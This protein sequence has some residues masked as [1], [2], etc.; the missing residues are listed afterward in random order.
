MHYGL[1]LFLAMQM[2]AGSAMAYE[3]ESE[4]L[5]H[6]DRLVQR[7]R[8]CAD[9]WLRSYDEKHG[10]F[11]SEVARDGSPTSRKRKRILL[12]SRNVYGL[13]RAFQVTGETRYLE[14]ADET[15][16]FM[17]Q[18]GWDET[19][20]GWFSAVSRSGEL[21]GLPD[22][23]KARKGPKGAFVHHYAMLGP[24][25]MLEAT[26]HE[27][28]RRWVKRAN[29]VLETK[30][31]DDRPKVGGYYDQADHDWSDPRNKTFT[32]EAD[33]ITGHALFHYLV[34]RDDARRKRLASIGD[35]LVTHFVGNMD[36]E[37]V[38]AAFPA[39]FD[40][41]WNIDRRRVW[42]GVGHFLKMAWHLSRCHLVLGDEKYRRGAERI[43]DQLLTY[44]QGT[45]ASLWNEEAGI[46]RG[47]LHWNTGRITQS[48]PYWW[49]CEEAILAGLLTWHVTG[50]DDCLRVADRTLSFFMDH[51]WDKKHG[52]V[53]TQVNAAGEVLDPAKGDAD[54]GAFH[55]IEL[56]YSTYLYAKLLYHE[57]PVTLHYRFQPRNEKRT[58]K[59]TPLALP[60]ESLE[61]QAVRSDGE[62][63]KDFDRV[64]RQLTLEPG[65]GGVFRVTFAPSAQ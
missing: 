32:S 45:G 59:L 53:F 9:F 64:S 31:H 14:R 33:A 24:L 42:V 51:F 56:F 6:P 63:F 29:R 3:P 4:H 49:T 8:Q 43:F 20:G 48:A 57:E 46:P 11:F 65:E 1:G 10:G 30:M 58:L 13:V 35:N 23:E 55:S 37:G 18:H 62:R 15:L 17:Y 2:L 50:R 26:D 36:A 12:Q 25:T 22:A 44:K 39:Y 61:I 38:K 60:D 34:T 52:E 16:R 21:A 47:Q 41:D 40:T 7:I 54:K 19:H 5:Q 28:H 27:T